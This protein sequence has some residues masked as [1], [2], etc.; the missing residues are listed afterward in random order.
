MAVQL[1]MSAKCADILP[2]YSIGGL[3]AGPV[4]NICASAL[5]SLTYQ[6]GEAATKFSIKN[7]VDAPRG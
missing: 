5:G 1:G 2:L 3:G 6:F 7:L 4:I